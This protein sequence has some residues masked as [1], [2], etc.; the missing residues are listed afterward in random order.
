MTYERALAQLASERPELVV[1][2]AENRAAIRGLPSLL[3]DRFIDVGICE[4]ALVGVAAGLALRGRV[5]VVHALA[6]FLT[7]RAFEFIR[8]DVGIPGLPVKLVGFVPGFLSDANGPTHQ[9]VEDIALMR[10]IPGME[11]FCPADVEE[12]AAALP[13]IVQRPKP[14]YIRYNGVAP[15]AAPRRKTAFAQA[16]V[17]NE[18]GD[19]TLLT[20]GLLMPHALEAARLL[21]RRH[22]QA[23]VVGLQSLEPLDTVTIC[24][25]ARKS[26]LLVSLEDHFVRGGLYTMLCE[27]LVAQRIHARVLPIALEQRWF[28]PGQLQD[29]LSAEGFS[30]PQIAER[31]LRT[32]E[33]KKV[34]QC[35]TESL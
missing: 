13:E 7:M 19:V 12:L 10:G 3:G 5:P 16:E 26:R 30:G 9:A 25:R 4:Q 31:V 6:A 11:I 32:L 15:A 33:S 23:C 14:C 35:E 28:A 22:V 29:V 18:D 24:Q 17:W 20:Y 21:Q 27:L 1:L 34:P 8:T 2:T